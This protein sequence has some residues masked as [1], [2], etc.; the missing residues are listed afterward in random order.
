MTRLHLLMFQLDRRMSMC[1]LRASRWLMFA[2]RVVERHIV[3]FNVNT[4]DKHAESLLPLP[5]QGETFAIANCF[6]RP[7]GIAESVMKLYA[8]ITPI[9][10]TFRPRLG[11]SRDMHYDPGHEAERFC[12]WSE[13]RCAWT[14]TL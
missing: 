3:C 11:L 5:G 10:M 13:N 8:D 1:K 14:N 4:C 2:P 9:L 7:P 12:T 6:E